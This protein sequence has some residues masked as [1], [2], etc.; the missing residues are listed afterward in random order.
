MPLIPAK[1]TACGA[2]LSVD[3]TKEAAVCPYCNTAYITEKAIQYYNTTNVTNINT[4]HADVVQITDQNTFENRIKSGYTFLQLNDYETAEKLFS[5]LVEEMPYDYR[6][7]LG[8]I[9]VHTHNFTDNNIN[10]SQYDRIDQFYR[11]GLQV[12][13][14]EEQEVLQGQC[15]SY[16]A[17]NK[18]RLQELKTEVENQLVKTNKTFLSI[19]DQHIKEI[20]DL[21]DQRDSRKVTPLTIYTGAVVISFLIALIVNSTSNVNNFGFFMALFVGALCVFYIFTLPVIS[22]LNHSYES[23][24][25]RI[26]Q[27][28]IQKHT[29]VNQLKQ[30]MQLETEKLQKEYFLVAGEYYQF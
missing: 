5:K 27:E 16:L 9:R 8:L 14:A 24:V 28:L 22:I 23:K 2:D 13:D 4:L 17:T 29:L 15:A 3:A 18:Q 11:K 26:N 19:I 10:K 7:W 6:A 25:Y 30:N 20:D 1:C 12:A 21:I